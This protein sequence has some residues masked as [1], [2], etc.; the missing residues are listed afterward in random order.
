MTTAKSC[1]RHLFQIRTYQS[2]C[3]HICWSSTLFE[4]A[5]WIWW[6]HNMETLFA[7]LALCEGN[8]PALVDSPLKGF[9][10]SSHVSI[11]KPLNG[12]S[13]FQ[14]FETSWCSWG[15]V[16]LEDWKHVYVLFH[17]LIYFNWKYRSVSSVNENAYIQMAALEVGQPLW[18]GLYK[19]AASNLNSK[20]RKNHRR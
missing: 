2:F 4:L 5:V 15:I 3:I 8:P 14:L 6:R 19:K 9:D 20:W 10:I 12:Q 1:N 7:L 16:A 17:C 13:S 18:I 11:N